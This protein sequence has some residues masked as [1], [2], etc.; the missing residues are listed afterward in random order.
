MADVD[1]TTSV[2]G[3]SQA[4][5]RGVQIYKIV[6]DAQ[7]NPLA[8]GGKVLLFKAKEQLVRSVR[9]VVDRAE[10]SAVTL[11]VG[12]ATDTD[13]FIVDADGNDTDTDK[14]STLALTEGTPNTVTGYSNGKFYA[15]ETAIQLTAS[16]ALDTLKATL[17]FE[18][19]NL[20]G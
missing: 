19:V 5:R 6:Y 15:T 7:E 17:Y 1:L 12:D 18:V 9:L 4:G 16:I 11:D 2:L 13:G 10:G 8:A 14:V 3:S 20:N